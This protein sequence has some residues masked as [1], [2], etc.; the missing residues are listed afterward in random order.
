MHSQGLILE[1]NYYPSEKP[2]NNVKALRK[3]LHTLLLL[4]LNIDD[5]TYLS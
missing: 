5:F 4:H 3:F 2:Q 1:L